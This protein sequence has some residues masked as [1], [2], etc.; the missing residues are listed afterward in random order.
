MKE[1]EAPPGVFVGDA[2]V[3]VV[4]DG[5]DVVF[6]GKDMQFVVGRPLHAAVEVMLMILFSPLQFTK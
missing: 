5:P 2:V 4:D 6:P 1:A 3:V